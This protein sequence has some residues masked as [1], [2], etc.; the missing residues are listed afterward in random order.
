MFTVWTFISFFFSVVKLNDEIS[1]IQDYFC[2]NFTMVYCPFDVL[3]S[4]KR[5]RIIAIASNIA[6]YS[7]FMQK[8]KVGK[9]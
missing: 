7:E 4:V 6:Y 1:L 8:G 2:N 5:T 9:G 3:P